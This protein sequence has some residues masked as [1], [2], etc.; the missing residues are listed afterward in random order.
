MLGNNHLQRRV[1][2]QVSK[3]IPVPQSHSVAAPE[4]HALE[5]QTRTELFTG[6]RPSHYYY[7]SKTSCVFGSLES[8]GEQNRARFF[9]SFFIVQCRKISKQC[10]DSLWRTGTL[11]GPHILLLAHHFF[12]MFCHADMS[13]QKKKKNHFHIHNFN[14]ELTPCCEHGADYI[15][16]HH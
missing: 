2:E 8:S 6:A 3:S 9:F 5:G 4:R 11:V 15:Q 12:Q 14:T 16:S 7:L 13:K 10:P 1:L